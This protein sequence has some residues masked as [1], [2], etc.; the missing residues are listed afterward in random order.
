MGMEGKR[1]GWEDG[2]WKP[3]YVPCC[4]QPA[5]QDEQREGRQGGQDTGIQCGRCRGDTMRLLRVV[6]R[7]EEHRGEALPVV[8][9]EL[10]C[11]CGNQTAMTAPVVERMAQINGVSLHLPEPV[12]DEEGDPDVW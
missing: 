10:G 11:P 5:K 3:E 7:A 12:K 9:C 6:R 4:I 2:W 1:L 8:L